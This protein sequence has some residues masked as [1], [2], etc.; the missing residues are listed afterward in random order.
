[1]SPS[2]VE[3]LR[4]AWNAWN[5]GD[6][7]AVFECFDPD[8][9]W[10]TTTF[11]GWPEVGVYKRHEGV[12]EFFEAWLSSWERYESGTE[13]FI[14]APDGRIVVVAWQRGYGTDSKAPVH[15]EFAQVTTVR[16]GLVLRMEAWSDRQAA[17][18]SVGL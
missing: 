8:V 15:M 3:I 7:D 2:D 12:R 14:V 1:M 5:A 18:D 9:E 17:L 11:E 10:D 16:D 4:R 6:L 13:E